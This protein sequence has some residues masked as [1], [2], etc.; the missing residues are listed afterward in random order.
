MLVNASNAHVGGGLAF[1]TELLPRLE[2]ALNRRGFRMSTLAAAPP[3]RTQ[4][5]SLRHRRVAAVFNVANCS[6]LSFPGAQLVAVRDR[7]LVEPSAAHPAANSRRT[8]ARRLSLDLALRQAAVWTV[9]SE[10]MRAPLICF[11]ARRRIPVGRIEVVPHGAPLDW[12]VAQMPPL[13]PLRILNPSFGASQKNIPLL[14]RAVGRLPPELA[15]QLTLTVDARLGATQ[16]AAAMAWCDASRIA[17]IGPVA[18]HELPAIYAAHHVLAFPSSVESLGIP[19][20]EALA[21]GRRVVASDLDWAHEAC[22]P[23]ATYARLDDVEA[24]TGALAAVAASIQG[25]GPADPID[26]T[27]W[28]RPWGWDTAGERYADL[29]VELAGP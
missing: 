16:L 14:I 12:P 25:V 22:G 15:P 8:A 17:F 2:T 29:L 28:L 10:S 19:L 20:L 21:A 7:I 1:A 6:L 26:R 11:A 5:L 27:E 9:P 18:R 24:W 13:P 3:L 23:F 4:L